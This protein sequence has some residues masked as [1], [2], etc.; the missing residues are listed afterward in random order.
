MTP[1]QLEAMTLNDLKALVYD[2]LTQIEQSQAN[3]K[4]LNQYI[5]K[6]SNS[7]LTQNMVQPKDGAM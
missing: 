2:Q 6:K 7:N 5:A 3:I 1:E 4:I